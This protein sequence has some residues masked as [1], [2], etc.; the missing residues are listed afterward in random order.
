[1]RSTPAATTVAVALWATRRTCIAEEVTRASHPPSFGFGAVS[2]EMATI[3]RR[4]AKHYGR[5]CG[6]RPRLQLVPVMAGPAPVG[7]S[8][9]V[10]VAAVETVSASV[11]AK[12]WRDDDANHWGRKE[13][14]RTRWWWRWR[15]VIVSRRR[16]AVRFNHIGASI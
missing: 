7:V 3:R 11:I 10:P 14:H 9:V 4:R 6:R 5:G 15:R 16:C 2:R 1:M 13:G 12:A 8:T